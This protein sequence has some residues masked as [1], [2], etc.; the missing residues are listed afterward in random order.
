MIWLAWRTLRWHPGTLMGT[1]VTLV[2][3]A[4][5][6]GAM[7]FVVEAD[8]RQTVP[9]E[10][11]A[12]VPLVVGTRGGAIPPELV[13]AVGAL[14]EVAQAVPEVTFP[15]GLY[16][17]GARVSGPGDQN[18]WPWGH[19][20]SSARL[21]PFGLSEGRAPR[22]AGEVVMDT[23]LAASARVAVGNRVEIAISGTVRPHR[24]VGLARPRA[25][26]RF[27]SALFFADDQVRPLTG[28][29][30]AADALGVYPGPGVGIEALR[31]AVTRV[32]E[33][34]NSPRMWTVKVVTGAERGARENNLPPGYGVNTLWFL[35]G[36]TALV[37]MGMIAATMGLSVRRRGMEI[38]VLRALGARPGQIRR[39]L[40]AEAVLLSV[41]AMA[42]AVPLAMLVAPVVAAWLRGTRA[43]SVA[44][45]QSYQPLPVLW[46]FLLTLGI[47]LAASLIAVRRAVR[48]RP[49]DALGEA[50]AE[51]GA[52]GRG[53]LVTGAVL[54]AG[55]GAAASFLAREAAELP[56]PAQ[57]ALRFATICMLVA[58]V[59]LVAPWV[60]PAA[61]RLV[62]A[63]VTGVSPV[64]GY[65]AV[66][67]VIFHHRRFAGAIG[68]LTLGVALVGVVAGVQSF[69]DWRL[70]ARAVA[71]VRADHVVQPAEG[72]G[73][74]SEDLRRSIM[75]RGASDAVGVGS[76]PAVLSV[77]GRPPVIATVVTGE[78]TR[79]FALSVRGRPI[80]GLGAREIAI[81]DELAGAHRLGLGSRLGVRLI[82][83]AEAA[84]YTV[85][86]I[87]SGA[88]ELGSVLLSPGGAPV[89]SLHE[90]VYV[91]GAAPGQ[92]ADPRAAVET[93]SRQEYVL[94]KSQKSAEAN[95]SLTYM[96]VMI[97]LLCLVAAVNNLCL[98]LLDRGREFA[99]LRHLG[100]RR[101]QVM[102]IV[103]WE[104]ALTV[105]PVL[106]LALVATASMA[107]V[108]AAGE[109]GGL[110]S[111]LVFIPAG[112]LVPLAA[113][114]LVSAWAGS[115][116]VVRGILGKGVR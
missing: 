67:N 43:L 45:E 3:A 62:R 63:A 34:Y 10:R 108:H 13:A 91:R 29:G 106:V 85:T 7:W 30:A 109:P 96:A 88:Q 58:G 11:Y 92:V 20:W 1:L 84:A 75:A 79:V 111:V 59:A 76:M 98:G 114:A 35:V 104:S 82:G 60:V 115:L 83:T 49:G 40:L 37:A 94:S 77:A 2:I 14:P 22:A 100:L 6:V 72:F 93:L 17:G 16:V 36:M 9:V 18:P 105:V 113:G 52:L 57:L 12:G 95:Q 24:V 47:A 56:E 101:G 51:G 71:E 38:A 8:S 89:S 19:G 80:G 42:A 87:F 54:L 99:G 44:Y 69:Y 86:S 65:L 110:G 4:S 112:W 25:A 32:A 70:A 90:R 23:R 102:R 68:S 97:A 5:A 55:A 61:G 50:P 78:A 107:L 15:A 33:P 103:T 73:A 116:L 74:L 64:G 41:V 26:W 28:R 66:A 48:I 39:M 53:R 21:T 31:A 27:Q 46:T 81:T